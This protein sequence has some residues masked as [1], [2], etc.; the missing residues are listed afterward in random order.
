MDS[1]PI[2]RKKTSE[3]SASVHST[4]RILVENREELG[5]GIAQASVKVWGKYSRWVLYISSVTSYSRYNSNSSLGL[6]WRRMST[7]ST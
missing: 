7:R 2:D 4:D 6:D 5:T 3:S 1:Q